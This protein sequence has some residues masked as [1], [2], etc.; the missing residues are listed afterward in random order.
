MNRLIPCSSLIPPK[1]IQLKITDI[2]RHTFRVLLFSG[3]KTD[4][5]ISLLHSPARQSAEIFLLSTELKRPT[6]DSL[7]DK[8]SCWRQNRKTT[9]NN[10]RIHVRQRK[11]TF[12]KRESIKTRCISL[13]MG[14]VYHNKSLR[15]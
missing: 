10:E 4:I 9:N 6:A 14:H 8:K 13:K 1:I 2:R 12:K 3:I 15:Q 5:F 11:V 7:Y